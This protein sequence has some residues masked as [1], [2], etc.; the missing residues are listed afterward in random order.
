VTTADWWG[1]PLSILAGALVAFPSARAHACV[2]VD[3]VVRTTSP[4]G[5]VFFVERG[6]TPSP[7]P[8][9]IV[10]AQHLDG[11]VASRATADAD[12]RFTLSSLAPGHYEVRVWADGLP[13]KSLRLEFHKV[14]WWRKRAEL[15]VALDLGLST[16][17][18]AQACATRITSAPT[19][20]AASAPSCLLEH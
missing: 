17:S 8:G 12:G 4:T 7:I 13:A 15:A 9:A 3:P 10:E 2:C 16:C 1:V 18:C 20:G 6:R 11:S 19:G 5:A 14:K